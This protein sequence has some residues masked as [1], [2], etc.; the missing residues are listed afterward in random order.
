MS[1]PNEAIDMVNYVPTQFSGVL[2]E[3][4]KKSRMDHVERLVLL[5]LVQYYSFL[6]PL[7]HFPVVG[8]GST[9]FQWPTDKSPPPFF[10]PLLPLIEAAGG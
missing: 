8:R 4:I 10:N 2:N 5:L 9:Q 7:R 1:L 3:P 6:D